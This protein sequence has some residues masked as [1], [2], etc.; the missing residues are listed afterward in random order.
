M[1]EPL[2]KGSE[3]GIQPSDFSPDGTV[4]LCEPNSNPTDIGM[5][6]W[7]ISTGAGHRLRWSRDGRELFYLE[8]R[9]AMHPLMAV[10]VTSGSSFAAGS[11]AM[12]FQGDYLG[13][14]TGRQVYD[15][16]LDGKRF[17]MIKPVEAQDRAPSDQIIVVLNWFEELKRLVPTKSR[18]PGAPL[19]SRALRD[20]S[21]PCR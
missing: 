3:R 5:G 10:S 9:G 20:H 17:L 14:N 8:D 19:P 2:T 21:T 7:Q 11:P 6:R 18:C 16:S 1:A 12:L 15:V 13:P 4:L